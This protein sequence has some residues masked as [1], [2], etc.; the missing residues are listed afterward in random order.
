MDAVL[1]D[2]KIA[3]VTMI[4]AAMA[5][6]PHRIC[7]LARSVE[8]ILPQVDQLCVYLNGHTELPDCLKRHNIVTAWGPDLGAAGKFFFT[9]RFKDGQ[10]F[11]LDDDIVY[12]PDYVSHMISRVIGSR[13]VACVYSRTFITPNPVHYFEDSIETVLGDALDHDRIVHVPGTGTS[14]FDL[15]YFAPKTD[16]IIEPN[17]ADLMLA[18]ICKQQKIPVVAVSRPR[19][20]LDSITPSGDSIWNRRYEYAPRR[21]ELLQESGS[22][23]VPPVISSMP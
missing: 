14:A 9:N 4:I 17:S 12:P 1:L 21:S 23:L 2:R 10:Y 8:S 15:S 5:T 16:D 6:M 18:I 22:W 11:T 7:S 20:W 13:T 19:A 3:L